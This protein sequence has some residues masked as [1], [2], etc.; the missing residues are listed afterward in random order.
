MCERV[1]FYIVILCSSTGCCSGWLWT[2]RWRR[3]V[4]VCMCMRACVWG[5]I[6]T[7]FIQFQPL[8]SH[9]DL[10]SVKSI[11]LK[12][13]P[14]PHQPEIRSVRWGLHWC[15]P[16]SRAVWHI[17]PMGMNNS[18]QR[19]RSSSVTV[20]MEWIHHENIMWHLNEWWALV[21]NQNI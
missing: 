7:G 21:L 16:A 9:I 14:D 17:R 20:S 5:L 13:A 3:C 2:V 1:Y 15:D 4:C 8:A 19:Q 12:Y 18:Q 10:T 11:W 6:F